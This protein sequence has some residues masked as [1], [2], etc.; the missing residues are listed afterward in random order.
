MKRRQNKH[1]T[2]HSGHSGNRAR[3]AH[4]ER[5]VDR[6]PPR[7]KTATVIFVGLYPTVLVLHSVLSPILSI[8]ATPLRILVS[9]LISVPLMVWIVV[10][11]LT[12]LFSRWLYADRIAC[13][14]GTGS[15]T[16]RVTHQPIPAESSCGS[17]PQLPGVE[18]LRGHN[19]EA[20]QRGRGTQRSPQRAPVGQVL[21][22]VGGTYSSQPHRRP[23]ANRN[24]PHSDRLFVCRGRCRP[25]QCGIQWQE[26]RKLL[27][28][29]Q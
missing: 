4:P 23:D 2:M 19:Y 7:Y 10:P 13:P 17:P 14:L 22:P 16:Q 21:A 12:R 26:H 24:Q 11:L 9:L 15:G 25:P 5:D 29:C 1:A 20:H 8:L 6:P 28:R 18:R 27:S 3:R